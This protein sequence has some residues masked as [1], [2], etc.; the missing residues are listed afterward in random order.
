ML[1]GRGRREESGVGTCGRTCLQFASSRWVRN[2]A[3]CA[4]SIREMEPFHCSEERGGRG[5][6]KGQADREA[7]S[8]PV[9]ASSPPRN[10]ALWAARKDGREHLW[11]LLCARVLLTIPTTPSL[12]HREARQREVK[13]SAKDHT[14]TEWMSQGPR[15]RYFSWFQARCAPA[16]HSVL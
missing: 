10:A 8:P 9:W 1:E 13:Q 15:P 3:R 7:V 11:S 2:A 4:L 5:R 16:P 12:F 14:A 6:T